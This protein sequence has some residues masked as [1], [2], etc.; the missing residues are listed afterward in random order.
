MLDNEL[1]LLQKIS[2]RLPE[3]RFWVSNF[4]F[5]FGMAF[6]MALFFSHWTGFGLGCLLFFGLAFTS[7]GF[8][9]F[10]YFVNKLKD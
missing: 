4:S 2:S 8:F 6:L 7:I 9:A 10:L 3:D 5:S 1:N